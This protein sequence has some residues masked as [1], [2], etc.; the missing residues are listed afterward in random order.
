MDDLRVGETFIVVE[1]LTWGDNGLQF[2]GFKSGESASDGFVVV[3]V[4]TRCD[5]GLEFHQLRA[6][7]EICSSHSSEETSID[8][9][10]LL[11]RLGRRL[12]PMS[13]T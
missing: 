8:S 1:R 7:K 4:T 2:H 12:G 10:L 9:N 5:D 11:F 3:P 6:R 13:S